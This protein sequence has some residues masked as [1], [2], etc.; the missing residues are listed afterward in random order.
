MSRASAIH[1]TRR[2]RAGRRAGGGDGAAEPFRAYARMSAVSGIVFAALFVA[3][4]VLVR[5]AP[6][7]DAPDSTYADF[8][9]VGRGNVLVTAGLYIV[10]FAGI[11]YLWH[12]SATRTLIEGMPGRAVGDAALA[13]ARI[14]IAFVCLL[15]T[16]TAAVGGV[17][18][19]T[20][21][22]SAPLPPPRSRG[23]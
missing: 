6:G 21:F 5:Q 4:L 18:L 15:F 19:L 23:R 20:V 17:A 7:L 3:A 10:P 16:G 14:G 12:M 9:S 8:Y 13:A 1:T 2:A 11:A 22:S